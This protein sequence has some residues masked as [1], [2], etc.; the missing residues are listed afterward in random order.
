MVSSGDISSNPYHQC[1]CSDN[2]SGLTRPRMPAEE[3]IFAIMKIE[4]ITSITG[5]KDRLLECK[6]RGNAIFTAYLDE[7]TESKTWNIKPAYNKFTD[8]RRNSRIHKILIHKYS[9][10]DITIWIDGKIRL[11]RDP[12]WYVD[13]Y[14]QDYD[15]AIYSH[16]TRDCLYDEAMICAKLK[17]DDPELIIEQAKYYEDHEWAKHKGLCEGGVIVRRNNERTQAFNEAW[18]ADYCRFSR[19]DQISLMPAM[20][21]SGVLVNMMPIGYV[22]YPDGTARREDDA[23]E[24]VNH[25]NNEGNWN[26]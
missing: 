6:S 11:L 19:R 1:R 15:M 4:V 25:L 26:Q 7:K 3:F 10:A 22:I 16:I 12:Q 5:K 20:E 18:W 8:P 23:V 21:K 24:L 13:N 17:L 9:D 14:L 2:Q